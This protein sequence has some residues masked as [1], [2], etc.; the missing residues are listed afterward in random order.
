MKIELISEV[1]PSQIS[2]FDCGVEELN[3]YLKRFAKKN[4]KLGI[5]RTFVLF[6]DSK[7]VG[8]YTISMAQIEF[9][10]LTHH[11]QQSLPRYPLPAVRIGRLAV[12]KNLQGK[13]FG[14][15]LLMNSLERCQRVSNE[16]AVFAV[17]VDAKNDL[18]KK[19]YIRY[20]FIPFVNRELSL[21]LPISTIKPL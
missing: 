2:S 21:Y 9:D 3:F 6:E 11:S 17:I 20:G 1:K 7:A 8:Y 16:I 19:F 13:G 14:E 15:Y 12:Q 18:A 10:S 5:G 4:D